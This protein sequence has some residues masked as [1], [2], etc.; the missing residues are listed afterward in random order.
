MLRVLTPKELHYNR[1]KN[2]LWSLHVVKIRH[3]QSNIDVTAFNS[4]SQLFFAMVMV[5]EK[6]NKIKL[7]TRKHLKNTLD[8]ARSAPN[9][10]FFSFVRTKGERVARLYASSSKIAGFRRLRIS[11]CGH[12]SSEK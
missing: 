6:L 3:I 10:N 4:D 1:N 5:A 7:S 12:F 2:V 9:T 11:W 8:G